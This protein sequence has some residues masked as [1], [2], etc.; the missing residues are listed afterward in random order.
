[1]GA[2]PCSILW[3]SRFIPPME[4]LIASLNRMFYDNNQV[5]YYHAIFAVMANYDHYNEGS[6]Y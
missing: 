2:V 3:K 5:A 1:M 4:A 6:D